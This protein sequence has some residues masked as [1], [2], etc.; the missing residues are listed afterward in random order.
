MMT[1]YNREILKKFNHV[2]NGTQ[3]FLKISVVIFSFL[4]ILG[5]IKYNF[6]EHKIN[7]AIIMHTLF[8]L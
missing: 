6:L 7:Y 2:T 5:K 4:K 1:P 3:L 8:A